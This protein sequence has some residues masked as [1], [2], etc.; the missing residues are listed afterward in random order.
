MAA[1]AYLHNIQ[2]RATVTGDH[3]IFR[4]WPE[5]VSKFTAG[6]FYNFEQDNLPLYDLEERT[7]FNWQKLGYP[8]NTPQSLHL[9]VSGDAPEELITCNSNI[10][11]TLQAALDALPKYITNNVRVTVASFGNLGAVELAGVN[12]APGSVLE[13]VNLNCYD[14]P[15]TWN[16]DVAT[17][18]RGAKPHYYD[19]QASS[20][21][22]TNNL[23]QAGLYSG[24]ISSG[25]AQ[26]AP[27]G[28]DYGSGGL[29][30]FFV[31]NDLGTVAGFSPRV[32]NF[33]IDPYLFS[34]LG[35]ATTSLDT[36]IFDNYYGFMVGIQGYTDLD[37]TF[38]ECGRLT[39][40]PATFNFSSVGTGNYINSIGGTITPHE[41]TTDPTELADLNTYDPS[42]FNQTTG[43][44]LYRTAP[45]TL[46]N[47]GLGSEGSVVKGTFYGSHCESASFINSTGRIHFRN[48]LCSGNGD[49]PIGFQVDGC[50]D[51]VLE[52]VAAANYG[53]YGICL[54]NSKVTFMRSLYIYRCY[55]KGF[56]ASFIPSTS[57]YEKIEGYPNKR[58]SGLFTENVLSLDAP[59]RDQS[60]GLVAFNSQV[61]FN[62]QEFFLYNLGLN[63]ADLATSATFFPGLNTA[64]IISRCSTG[65]R[66]VNSTLE[67]GHSLGVADYTGKDAL[68]RR[69]YLAIE[70]NANYGID[71]RDSLIDF[72]GYLEVYHNVRGIRS[73]GS[74]VKLDSFKI[75]K[76]HHY[77]LKLD[78]SNFE[79]GTFQ[80]SS[81]AA[82]PRHDYDDTAIYDSSTSK[83]HQ[84]LFEDNGQHII[85]YNSHITHGDLNY[86]LAKNLGRLI[87]RNAH[88]A[89]GNSPHLKPAVYLNNSTARFIHTT[90]TR[91]GAANTYAIGAHLL[92]DKNSDVTFL[93]SSSAITLFS[94]ANNNTFAQAQNFIGLVADNGSTIKFRGPTV[95]YD[96]AVNVLAQNNSNMIFEPHKTSTNT[97]DT[98]SF[99][100]SINTNHTM[101]EV[102]ALRSCLVADKSSSIIMEDLGNFLQSW[103]N[104]YLTGY[105]YDPNYNGT[106]TSAGFFQFY[107]SPNAESNLYSET[108][109]ATAINT[110]GNTYRMQQAT[111]DKFY[112]GL[113]YVT[114]DPFDFS[115]I[116]NGG[117]CLRALNNSNVRVR[118][119]NFPCGW[120]NTSS[121]IYDGTDLSEEG[122]CNK[123]FIWNVANN[124][125]L[126]AD[127]LSVSAAYPSDVGYFGPSAVWFSG[128]GVTLG[129]NYGAPS[130]TPDTSSLS[131][132]DAFGYGLDNVWPLPNGSMEYYG[133]P[134]PQNQG[135]FRL[136]VGVDSLATQLFASDGDY[137]YI[138]Q[139]FAQGYNASGA[140]SALP[141][142]S[143]VYGKALRIDEV[144]NNIDVSGFYYCNEFVKID[145]NSIMLDKSAGNTFANAKNGAMGTSG[146]PQICTIYSADTFDSGEARN[147]STRY[148]VGFRSSNVFDPIERN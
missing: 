81:T 58:L 87:F 114:T 3:K 107:P 136:Y 120:W 19:M 128:A 132:L 22:T 95:I 93:G 145:P 140:L 24:F 71:L 144:T 78:S 12:V 49:T 54:T 45:V 21:V 13:I 112:W 127:H 25:A 142:A 86:P 125:T 73:N 92:A 126:H 47:K 97:F 139:L 99:P 72:K 135:P 148:G 116:T 52:S 37:S 90:S 67:G 101:V 143:A 62:N 131:V 104:E 75:D 68:R 66:L 83:R 85:S 110:R 39:A 109:F 105:S 44:L 121:V 115:A 130:S 29:A 69:D 11:S 113:N 147:N 20:L 41:A 79:Y 16:N 6:S 60:A 141:S 7:Y 23:A 17:G 51:L 138:P 91:D 118:N 80:V 103:D 46:F 28:N 36:R 124:S 4:C 9:L 65:I 74:T 61:V 146:R 111:P 98:I 59:E 106:Y 129:P 88:G 40:G 32:Q 35:G 48:F 64:K 2:K 14:K 119:V 94:F 70:G 122:F 89:E 5:G 108:R 30:D 43:S 50:P 137:G 33:D 31:R 8:S 123:L 133:K 77:G 76:N 42:A 134:T 26:L 1:N 38:A 117:T 96:G 15:G 18:G 10:F 63:S 82:V 57:Y 102:K 84:F 55:Q 34:S 56:Y 100:L 27:V 53:K